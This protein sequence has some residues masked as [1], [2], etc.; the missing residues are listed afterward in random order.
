MN[1]CSSDYSWICK[2]SDMVDIVQTNQN[3]IFSKI[4]SNSYLSAEYDI[5]L[6]KDGY[7][8]EVLSLYQGGVRKEC[9]PNQTFSKVP[10]T[11][12]LSNINF[13]ANYALNVVR[14]KTHNLSCR[15]VGYYKALHTAQAKIKFYVDGTANAWIFDDS[16]QPNLPNIQNLE[17]YE[18]TINVMKDEFYYVRFDIV[19]LNGG[20]GLY[21]FNII[22]PDQPQTIFTLSDLYYPI[23]TD[24]SPLKLD[25]LV[26][27]TLYFLPVPE[28]NGDMI[29]PSEIPNCSQLSYT[30]NTISS[31]W[32]SLCEHNRLESGI[33][34]CEKCKEDAV[35][36]DNVCTCLETAYLDDQNSCQITNGVSANIKLFKV[37]C[38]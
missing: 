30:K 12:E 34:T 14:Y 23:R 28:T 25:T 3:I 20:S 7:T 31:T 18:I 9:W 37:T 10:I 27:G 32:S 19:Y 33:K 17:P 35:L 4:D 13:T 6:N 16:V 22:Y 8:I 15:V 2:D 24:Y 29:C 1:K 26:C 38:I 21:D 36:Y 5:G 11:I